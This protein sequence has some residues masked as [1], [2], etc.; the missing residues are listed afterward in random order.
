MK[1]VLFTTI[2]LLIIS[3]I[4]FIYN[5]HNQKVEMSF[6]PDLEL[7]ELV[8]KQIKEIKI[9]QDEIIKVYDLLIS[10]YE[11]TNIE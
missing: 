3:W 2:T 6:Q 10:H 11:K 1:K 5:I 7:R 9:K 4:T 8:N